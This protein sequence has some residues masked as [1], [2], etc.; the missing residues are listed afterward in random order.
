MSVVSCQPEPPE[1]IRNWRHTRPAREW[2]PPCSFTLST[3]HA[4]PYGTDSRREIRLSTCAALSECRD[5]ALREGEPYGI[6]GGMTEHERALAL[7][8]TTLRYAGVNRQHHGQR[9]SGF[10][11]A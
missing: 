10:R 6:W 8:V 7:G 1:I 11:P 3:S 4:G 2:T 9:P 5:F